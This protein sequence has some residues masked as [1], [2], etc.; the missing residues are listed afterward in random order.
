MEDDVKGAVEVEDG[1]QNGNNKNLITILVTVVI[2]VAVAVIYWD[3]QNQRSYQQV[4]AQATL[5]DEWGLQSQQQINS[6]LGIKQV[7]FGRQVSFKNI[8]ARVSPSVVSV[9]VGSS[10]LNQGTPA[11]QS[12][13]VAGGQGNGSPG[14]IFCPNCNVTV[15]CPGGG[16]VWGGTVS[17]P[18]CGTSMLRSGMPWR[19]PFP[20]Q[21]PQ[22]QQAVQKQQG[23]QN[24]PGFQNQQA[25][26]LEGLSGFGQYVWGGRNGGASMGPGGSLICSNC[27]T[28]I[29]HKTGVPGYSVS[30]PSCGTQMMRQGVAGTYPDPS[31]VR[32]MAMQENWFQALGRGGSGVIV[33][34]QGYVLTNHHVIHGARSITV[35]LTQGEISKTYPAKVIDEAPELDFAI[36]KIIS[37]GEVFTPAVIGNSSSMSVGD[38]VLTIGSPFGLQQTVTSGIISNTKRTLTVGQK[39]FTNF[40]QTDAP[41]NPGSSGGPLININGEVI[42]ITTAIYSPTQAFSGIGFASPIDPAKA[43]FPEF[44]DV[45]SN[46]AGTIKSN[47]P[48][49][50]R[51]PGLQ[52]AAL[53]GT[54]PWR[55]PGGPVGRMQQMAN[56]TNTVGRPWL[57]M[58]VCPVDKNS[59]DFLGLPMSF[60][61]LVMDVCVNSPCM[62]AG[63]QRSD[64]IFRVENQSVKDVA[65]L[66]DLMSDKKV[67]D[68]VKF[69]VYR[70]GKKTSV[71]VDLLAKLWP[72]ANG[73]P[74]NAQAVAWA[75]NRQPPVLS[76]VLLG[77]EVGAGNIEVLGMELN[78]LT[79][80][81]AQ[82]SGVPDGVRGLL[83]AESAGQAAIAGL[84]A[85]D[86]IAAVNGQPVETVS[87][88]INVM[89]TASLA[90]GIS[91]DVYRQGQW[92]NLTM[93]N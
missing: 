38:E 13:P 56:T 46:V 59:R 64:V 72:V 53:Q 37:N 60:G 93:V 88:F 87:G 74:I 50:A 62:A 30:C 20:G 3:R 44:I 55:P 31:Q 15:P 23:F 76:G 45:T 41:I 35:V 8:V 91:L 17:C 78:E 34:S 85:N 32:Q 48:G 18:G 65:M 43:V 4:Q 67:G 82:A 21:S 49:W 81:L 10:F 86:V 1:E 52:P 12:Q 80:G 33:N 58:R 14:T 71:N 2:L 66:E 42:G 27:G 75:A 7:A 40:I 90:D 63:L 69:T 68:K 83:I 84:L 6:A 29:I 39:T 28:Q 19:Y 79:P 9:N 24:R 89:N 26:T 57:G 54:N 36:L 11:I 47:I 25:G 73:T 5:L 51:G 77:G 22:N 16:Q 70:D 92:Y 61:V